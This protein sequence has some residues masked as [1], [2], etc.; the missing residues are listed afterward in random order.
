[1][2]MKILSIET[3]CDETGIC[4]LTSHT[5]DSVE[6]SGNALAS[7]IDLHAQ[8]GGVFPA[9]AKREHTEKILPLTIEALSQANLLVQEKSE[10]SEIQKQHI[11][12]ICT[13][14]TVLADYLID[15]FSSYKKPDIDYIA[16][17]VGP[18]LEPALW[19]GVNTAKSF[20]TIWNIPLIPINHMEGHIVTA[21]IQKTTG[22]NFIFTNLAL[23]AL[24]LLVSGGH[25]ELVLVENIGHYTKIGQ[26]RDDA[27][28]EAF[29]KIARMLGLA[30]PGGPKVSKLAKEFRASGTTQPFILPRPMMHTQDYDFSFS[31]IKTAMLYTIRDLTEQNTRELTDEEKS[32]LACAFEDAAIEVLIK[33]TMRAVAE[34]HIQTL[35]IGGGVAGNTYLKEQLTLA[36]NK[37]GITLLTPEQ[38]LATD[39]AV[40]IGLAATLQ[41]LSGNIHTP[42]LST[43]RAD[44]NMTL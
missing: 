14:D 26:T 8:Y 35:I 30:Y 12:D 1:M 28:G 42:E 36:T 38:W 41:V 31:G 18:G 34:H 4:I 9:M 33:K 21:V 37:A 22:E 24:A 27:V 2:G 25:T 44:G 29:D 39:N 32:A 40:M 16:C 11:R 17:T 10:L 19:V 20:A 23:P 7:Q 3:S 15:F 5:P 43:I 6:I 13:R